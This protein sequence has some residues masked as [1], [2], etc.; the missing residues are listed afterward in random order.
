MLFLCPTGSMRCPS[1]DWRRC[2][3][4]RVC[5]RLRNIRYREGWTGRLT[6]WCEYGSFFGRVYHVWR[7]I[8]CDDKWLGDCHLL[9]R[10]AT[11]QRLEIWLNKSF[12]VSCFLTSSWLDSPSLFH[13]D[14]T[15]HTFFMYNVRPLEFFTPSSYMLK[16]WRLGDQLRISNTMTKCAIV[17]ALF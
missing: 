10:Y 9:F 2:G 8:R 3:W 17:Y 12:F 16:R 4:I 5:S 15:S 1:V 7:S 6:V 14:V 11:V 13:Y